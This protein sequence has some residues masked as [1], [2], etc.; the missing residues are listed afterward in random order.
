LLSETLFV[1]LLLPSL[2]VAERALRDDERPW[3]LV[4]T[5]ACAG[6]LILVRTHAAAFLLAVLVCLA[7]RRRFRAAAG[8]AV[9]A[10]VIVAPWQVWSMA[11][12]G[13]ISGPLTGSYGS[14]VGWWAE[15]A[16]SGGAA[17]F[18][19]TVV[20]NVREVAALLADRFSLS[21]SPTPRL[22]TAALAAVMATVGAYRLAGRAPVTIAFI[23]TYLAVLFVWPFTPWRFFYAVWP[24]VV[25]LIGETLFAARA[26]NNGRWL[27][28]AAGALIITGTVREEMRAYRERSWRQG[29]QGATA[30]ISPLVSWVRTHTS[31]GDVV[32]GEGEQLLYL[33][34]ERQTVPLTAFT[35]SEYMAPRS[36]AENS[37]MIVDLLDHFPIRYVVTISPPMVAASDALASDVL[38]G[39]HLVL[40]E[41]LPHGGGA[42]R[43]VGQ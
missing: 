38:P 30:Q 15:G 23:V 2:V 8:V 40:L 9:V 43:V 20:L 12:V 11:H 3:M 6:L 32:A 1:A 28:I 16:R 7:L 33:F 36:R 14:Y 42:Y 34:A 18:I 24:I 19:H 41:R 37:A 35:A 5:G 31:P 39:R 17:L 27:A 21:D 10:I 4:V 22:A 29:A 25:I 26:T 13:E